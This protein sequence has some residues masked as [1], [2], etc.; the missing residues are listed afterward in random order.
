MLRHSW[1]F[2]GDTGACGDFEEFFVF[3]TS[4]AFCRTPPELPRSFYNFNIF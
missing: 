3:F 1:E 4:E 2:L